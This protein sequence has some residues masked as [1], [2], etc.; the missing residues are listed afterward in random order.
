MPSIPKALRHA[1]MAAVIGLFLTGCQTAMTT[2]SSP[3]HLPPPPQTFSVPLRFVEHNFSV[4]AYNVYGCR[5]LYNG[6]PFFVGGDDEEARAQLRPAPEPGYRDSWGLASYL[7]VPNFPAPAEVRWRS[8]DGVERHAKVDIA[9]IFHEQL[10]WHQVSADQIVYQSVDEAGNAMNIGNDPSIF[11][12][13]N[14]R[15]INVYIGTSVLT[16]SEQKPGN[17]H[18]RFRNDLFLAWS[19]T[20]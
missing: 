6:H 20:Y 7:G 3:D 9:G 4:R 16:R 2:P 11:L 12:E 1:G 17:R 14:D 13:V 18:S 19:G 10:V 8:A 5:V 15:T